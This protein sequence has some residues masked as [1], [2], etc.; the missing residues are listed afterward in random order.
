[1]FFKPITKFYCTGAFSIF[2]SNFIRELGGRLFDETYINGLEDVDLSV[3]LKPEFYKF[4]NFSIGTF[5]GQ[6]LGID[7]SRK[8]R[9]VANLAYFNHKILN[10]DFHINK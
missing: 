1:M 8:L 3:R 5:G 7:F 10:G 4:I 2:S 9:D 6:S